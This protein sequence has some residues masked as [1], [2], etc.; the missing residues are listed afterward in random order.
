MRDGAFRQPKR[1]GA[2]RRGLG[3]MGTLT[4]LRMSR[5][6]RVVVTFCSFS[7]VL[8]L[9]AC[10]GAKRSGTAKVPYELVEPGVARLPADASA[11]NGLEPPNKPNTR[12]DTDMRLT[13]LSES[14]FGV[15][16]Y[17]DAAQDV[18]LAQSLSLGAYYQLQATLS[19]RDRSRRPRPSTE[20]GLAPW[21]RRAAKLPR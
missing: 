19:T 5:D 6:S 11:A 15:P 1:R 18:E 2:L 7:V 21:H 12:A 3:E 9:G 13:A 16:F 14:N 10:K 17:P 8:F 4:R 20:R